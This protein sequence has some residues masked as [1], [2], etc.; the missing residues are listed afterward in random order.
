LPISIFDF[1]RKLEKVPFRRT[2]P[3]ERLFACN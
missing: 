1:V 3:S 2:D